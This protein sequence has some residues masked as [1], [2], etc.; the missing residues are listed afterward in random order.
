[1]IQ[2]KLMFVRLSF[3]GGIKGVTVGQKLSK[4]EGDPEGKM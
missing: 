2:A 3:G 1:M 4:D